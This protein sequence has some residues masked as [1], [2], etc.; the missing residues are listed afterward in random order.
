MNIFICLCSFIFNHAYASDLTLREISLKGTHNS[1]HKKPFIS[2]SESFN[3][4]HP[5]LEKQLELGIRTFE[6]DLHQNIFNRFE[7][8]HIAFVDSAS[9]CRRF[10]TCLEQISRWSKRHPN[11]LPILITIEIKVSTGGKKEIHGF[12]HMEGPVREI[13]KERLFSPDDLKS[14]HSSL[15]EAIEIDGWPKLEKLRGKV[16]FFMIGEDQPRQAYTRGHT[17]LDGRAMFVV[18]RYENEWELPWAIAT[19]IDSP[20]ATEKILQAHQRDQLV[21]SN[22]CDNLD[23]DELCYRKLEEAINNGVHSLHDDYVKPGKNRSYKITFPNDKDYICNRVTSEW[24]NCD[25]K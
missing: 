16:L 15:K 11:H 8:Y 17:N 25:I 13:F 4:Q 6:I 24:N 21:F 19:K 18:S 9:H 3:Y 14:S 20:L 22:G 2:F 5:S 7:V 10:S 12:K 23:T 1:Y